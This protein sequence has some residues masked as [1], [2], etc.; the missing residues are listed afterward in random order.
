MKEI[1]NILI[2]HEYGSINGGASK[3]AIQSA[4]ALA[5]EGFRVTYFC[6]C[7]PVDD[8]LK[9]NIDKVICLNQHDILTNPSRLKAIIQGIWNK[10]AIIKLESCLKEFNSNTT[11]V[12]IHEWAHALSSS[13]VKICNK[14]GYKPFITFH[15]Y[16]C[17]CPNGGF[18]NYQ[19]EEIC[20]LK[21][22]S[23][24]CIMCNCDSRS[25]L[26]KVWR[27]IRQIVQDRYIRYNKNYH[28]IYISN[29]SLSKYQDFLKC[30][31]FSFVHN[32]IEEFKINRA[33]I[34]D[35]NLLAFIGR[36]SPE[37][38][39]DLFCEAVERLGLKG[40]V[41]GN[42]P[43][44]ENL[45]SRFKKIEFVGWKT[46][47]ELIPYLMKVRALVFPSKWYEVAPLITEEC[48]NVGIPCIVPDECAASDYISE[49]LNGFVFK[50]GSVDSLIEAIQKLD[51]NPCQN[52]EVTHYGINDH[53]RRLIDAY[54]K[55]MN[56]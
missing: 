44:E 31:N 26:H 56:N 2:I 53:V 48:L 35:N 21:P 13:V 37:K 10:E 39:V 16:F 1:K 8:E 24:K 50:S 11:V 17:V 12:H 19:K 18:Y 23:N 15:E 49:G 42:G 54:S 51:D 9:A 55:N 34:S 45:K 20:K 43:L 38:G 32:P 25:Y 46:K 52:F 28:T 29:F 41:I 7:S 30:K 5:K 33:N 47:E 27:V 4:I 14:M 3:V 6:A 22:M 36:L 40:I